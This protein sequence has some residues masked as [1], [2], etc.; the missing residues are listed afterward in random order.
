MEFLLRFWVWFLHVKMVIFE[1][2]LAGVFFISVF[3]KVCFLYRFSC[4]FVAIIFYRC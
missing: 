4:Y 1:G 3:R 2:D